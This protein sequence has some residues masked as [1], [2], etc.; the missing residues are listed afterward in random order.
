M[1]LLLPVRSQDTNHALVCTW[2]SDAPARACASTG[3]CMRQI[4]PVRH[5]P[6]L[7]Y[8]QVGANGRIKTSSVGLH[9]Q[10][11]NRVLRAQPVPAAGALNARAYMHT[12]PSAP[13]TAGAAAS[14]AR[15]C[16]QPVGKRRAS[17]DIKCRMRCK[18]KW[19]LLPVYQ[20]V[21][22][23]TARRMQYLKMC[24]RYIST[25]MRH[26]PKRRALALAYIAHLWKTCCKYRK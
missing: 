10:P 16:M 18:L 9:A 17:C 26:T 8:W 6:V 20:G 19:Q 5:V 1:L 13:S 14:G 25:P 2:R 15:V 11:L 21:R 7:V 3:C 4:V 22:T 23:E 12:R 24:A